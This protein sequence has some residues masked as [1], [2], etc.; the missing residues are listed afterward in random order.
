MK[1][2]PTL[3]SPLAGRLFQFVAFKRIQGY[4]YA[5]GM[6]RLKR[7]DAFLVRTRCADGVLRPEQFDDYR[8]DIRPLDTATQAK[9]LSTVRQFSLYLHALEAESAVLPARLLPRRPRAIRFYPLS[10]AQVSTLMAATSILKHGKGIRTHCLRFLF[11]LLYSTG[12]RIGEALALNLGD[13]DTQQ[14]TLVVRRGKFRK[15]RLVPMSE[16]TREAMNQW[17]AR[18]RAYAG[19]E[20]DS[21]LLVVDWNRRPNRDQVADAFAR[22]CAHCGIGGEPPPRLHDLRHNYACQC[23]AL[24]RQAGEDVDALLPALANA[25]GHVNFRATQLYLHLDAAALQQA[26]DR[27]R[28]HVYPAQEISR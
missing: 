1:P 15:E 20:A 25:M 23:L 5:D 12:L 26:A 27:F 21:P 11:G 17:L 24:W 6:D 9:H 2:A 7:L 22:L 14:L 18:R 28:A 3:V 8:A 19:S 10:P 16:S 13:V 4:A